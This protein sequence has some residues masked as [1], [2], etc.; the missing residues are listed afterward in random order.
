L[1]AL[2]YRNHKSSE[3]NF[4]SFSLYFFSLRSYS[5]SISPCFPKTSKLHSTVLRT[6]FFSFPSFHHA[7]TVS[8]GSN[9]TALEAVTTVTVNLDA[10][11]S[12]VT[13][14]VSASPAGL[15]ILPVSSFSFSQDFLSWSFVVIASGTAAGVVTISFSVSDTADYTAPASFSTYI[16]GM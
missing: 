9:L 2:C 4:F 16:F 11:T 15:V 5:F 10:A 3:T 6:P 7:V 12:S 13:L 14:S 8:Q 1:Y